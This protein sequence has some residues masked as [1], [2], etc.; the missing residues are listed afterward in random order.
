MDLLDTKILGILDHDARISYS[1]LAKKVR[2]GRDTVE[3]RVSRLKKLGVITGYRTIINPYKLGLTLYK[4]YLRIINNK[5]HLEGFLKELRSRPY[6]FWSVQC[7]GQ[8]D[9]IMSIA[10]PSAYVFHQVQGELFHLVSDLILT[11]EVYTVVSF[12]L[13]RKKYLSKPGTHWFE[14]GGA[15]FEVKLDSYEKQLLSIMS[16]DARLSV[17]ELARRIGISKAMVTSRIERLESEKVI[18]GY[19]T[20]MDLTRLGIAQF[21][22]QL[23]LS[24][25]DTKGERQLEQYCARHPNITCLI[26]QIGQCRLEIEIQIPNLNDYHIVIQD[27]REQFPYLIKNVTTSLM[28]T[29]NFRW[30]VESPSATGAEV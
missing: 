11:S 30:M 25:Y 4:S 6:V 24:Q 1:D 29:D 16:A 2:R 20:E 8:W 3:Y 10:A 23:H 19:R 22:A 7:D 15:P 9:L 14:V 12:Q 28:H 21:K 17:A 18:L 27:I 13:F 26:H 5:K